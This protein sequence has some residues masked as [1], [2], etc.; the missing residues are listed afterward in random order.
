MSSSTFYQLK[1]LTE[2]S[3]NRDS[4]TEASVDGGSFAIP[5]TELFSMDFGFDGASFPE[6]LLQHFTNVSRLGT[7]TPGQRDR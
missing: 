4:V 1:M 7:S 5:L 6:N 2:A 3:S